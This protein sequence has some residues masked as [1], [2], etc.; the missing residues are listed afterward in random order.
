METGVMSAPDVIV[1]GGGL[2]GLSASI[3][4]SDSGFRVC[5]IEKSPRLGGRATSYTLPGGETID[6]C[7]HVTLGCCTNLADFYRRVGVSG[8]ISHH[9]RIL[10]ASPGGE[11][12]EIRRSGLPAPLHLAPSFARFPFLSFDDKRSIA[13]AMLRIVAN[14]GKPLHERTTTMLEWLKEQR[15]TAHAIER[16]W[17]TVLVSALNED[18]DRM[19]AAYGIDVFWKAFLVNPNGMRI[20][21]PAVPLSELYTSCREHL[22][23]S[24]VVR[25]RVG[26]VEVRMANGE[27]AA[28]RLDDGSEVTGKYYI[29]ATTFDRLEKFLPPDLRSHPDFAGLS[30][31]RTSPITSVHLWYDRAVMVE[32]S[33]ACV[34]RTIQWVF[35]KT[36]GQYLQ[37]VISASHRLSSMSQQQVVDLCI[38]ELGDVIPATRDA[39][40]TRSVVIRENAATFAPEPDCDHWRPSQ[41]TSIR[42][43]FV[44]GDWTRTGWPATME[45]AVRSGYQAAEIILQLEGR[46]T[47]LIQPELPMGRFMRI[48]IR[49]LRLMR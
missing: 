24:G 30:R 37:L 29:A 42:N 40:L 46:T 26:V 39:G 6:N 41:R 18:L 23:R 10:F 34:D 31:F 8:K 1:I 45:S 22:E 21:I 25:T 14:E 12:A 35:N 33:L 48:L 4:L 16:F 7:Q 28:L 47:H 32:P 2:A 17:K 20:G 5:L 9:D 15:Q 43:F 38:S 11:R 44:A 19:D 27:V 36:S 49:V 3:A 13:R